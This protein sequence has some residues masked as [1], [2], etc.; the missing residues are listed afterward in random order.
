MHGRDFDDIHGFDVLEV[1]KL[2]RM[3]DVDLAKIIGASKHP[4]PKVAD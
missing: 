1:T 3:F 4:D 2:V